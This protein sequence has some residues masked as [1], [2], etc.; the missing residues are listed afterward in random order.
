MDVHVIIPNDYS[1][2]RPLDLDFFRSKT[3]LTQKKEFLDNVRISHRI[4]DTEYS[5]RYIQD[6]MRGGIEVEITQ[7][8]LKQMFKHL[9]HVKRFNGWSNLSVFGHI[10][11]VISLI[12]LSGLKN[13]NYELYRFL[14]YKAITHDLT[15]CFTTD[16][17]S[18][19]KTKSFSRLESMLLEYFNLS[20]TYIVLHKHKASFLDTPFVTTFEYPAVNALNN[21]FSIFDSLAASLEA[22]FALPALKKELE[23]SYQTMN[24]KEYF[25][26]SE[27]TLLQNL[28][29]HGIVYEDD[30]AFNAVKNTALINTESVDD[31]SNII[32]RLMKEHRIDPSE[33]SKIELFTEAIPN[34][35]EL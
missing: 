4:Y 30:D 17:P 2:Q 29:R 21:L 9:N 6:C 34:F 25:K 33:N 31:A 23:D 19:L 12:N 8:L 3:E 24:V 14:L 18:Y 13:S 16:V 10:S 5:N 26:D 20:E 11:M 15:E 35:N 27:A 22:T 32:L 28:A 1:A 7:K